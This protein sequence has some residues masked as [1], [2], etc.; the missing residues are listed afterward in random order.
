MF[1]SFGLFF[2]IRYF[3]INLKQKILFSWY[4]SSN[5]NVKFVIAIKI[6]YFHPEQRL[7]HHQKPTK[8]LIDNNAIKLSL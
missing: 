4:F 3:V 7:T 5:W 8:S 6:V 1:P 2:L